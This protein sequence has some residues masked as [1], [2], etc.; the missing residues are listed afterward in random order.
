MASALAISGTV[1]QDAT[2]VDVGEKSRP[3]GDP[4]DGK[5]SWVEKVTGSSVGGMQIPE[6]CLEDEFVFERLSL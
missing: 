2:M 6:N 1:A 4:P 3:P 5:V